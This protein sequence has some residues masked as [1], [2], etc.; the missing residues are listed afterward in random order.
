MQTVEAIFD[1]HVLRPSI[2]LALK[3]NCRVL[4]TLEILPEKTSSP[5]E[6]ALAKFIDCAEGDENLSENYKEKY[7]AHLSQK[8]GYR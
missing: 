7:S 8:Y 2:P 3:T 1:G 6:D 4:I 5:Y